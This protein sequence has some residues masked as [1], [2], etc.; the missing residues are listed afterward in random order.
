MEQKTI[1]IQGQ[2]YPVV[3]DFQ[4]LL[5]FEEIAKHGFFEANFGKL[6]E[7]I[8]IIA[9]AVISADP[10]SDITYEKIVGKGD[11][12]AVAEITSNFAIVLELCNAYFEVPEV[13]KKNDH[14]D[15]EDEQED[16]QED[17]ETN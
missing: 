1:T 2:E 15:D 7:R 4:T 3:F 9:A 11:A 14:P 13:E 16:Q 8:A 10:D 17:A 12:K 5:N 6:F